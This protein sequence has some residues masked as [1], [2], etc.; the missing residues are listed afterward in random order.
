MAEPNEENLA[1][2]SSRADSTPDVAEPLEV[3]HSGDGE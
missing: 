1:S 3:M 2:E